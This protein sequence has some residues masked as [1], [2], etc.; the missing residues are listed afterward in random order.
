M[1]VTVQQRDARQRVIDSFLALCAADDMTRL[2]GDLGKT[3]FHKVFFAVKVRL[4]R[5]GSPQYD[6]VRWDFGPFS[7]ALR[8]DLD[9]L[10][11]RGFLR[12]GATGT[13]ARGTR[14]VQA[15]RSILEPPNRSIFTVLHEESSKRARWTAAR[16]KREAYD[17]PVGTDSGPVRLEDLPKGS[18][19]V[20][21]DIVVPEFR[22]GDDTLR[23]LAFSLTLSPER[24]R[25]AHA[26]TSESTAAV[27]RML[28]E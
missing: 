1:I 3:L 6:F 27:R 20:F 26:F 17:A 28:A 24:V 2:S 22:A 10:E 18:G 9:S 12:R 23:E 25:R 11:E 13:T 14:L 4:G 5:R 15:F 8:D 7:F 19:L 21:A 16:A